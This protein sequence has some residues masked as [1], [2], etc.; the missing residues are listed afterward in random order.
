MEQYLR[1]GRLSTLA[2]DLGLRLV[3]TAVSVGW[4]IWLWGVT[5]P[6]LLAG[7]AL[8]IVMQM[9]LRLLRRRTVQKREMALR[10][11]LGGEMM[12]EEM[13]LSPKKQAHF[14]SALLLGSKYPLVMERVT[15]DGMLC[16]SGEE[17]LLVACLRVPEGAEAGL[18]DL[19]ALQR[20]CREHGAS[21]GVACVTGRL[22]KGAEGYAEAALVPLRLIGRDVLLDLAGQACPATDEQL[23]ALG[24]R[25]RRSFPK[26]SLRRGILR[27]DKAKRYLLYGTGLMLLYLLTGL[28]YYPIPGILCLFLAVLS[29]YVPRAPE[30]L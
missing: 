20:A 16:R 24:Q 6:A 4:F 9:G 10:R 15:E 28:W 11:R 30:K 7:L 14:Q 5:V 29:R 21:R 23:V 27:R 26:G 3:L 8:A 22:P 17:T 25:R 2:D 12:L 1:R 13:M 19:A 18:N